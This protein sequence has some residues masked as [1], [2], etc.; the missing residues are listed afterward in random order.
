MSGTPDKRPIENAS[1]TD[2]GASQ[3]SVKKRRWD[4]VPAIATL[5]P[6]IAAIPTSPATSTPTPSTGAAAKPNISDIFSKVASIKASLKEKLPAAAS[7]ISAVPIKPLDQTDSQKSQTPTK[8]IV[9]VPLTATPSPTIAANTGL[10]TSS[11]STPTLGFGAARPT[12]TVNQELIDRVRQAS[13]MIQA[14]VTGLSIRPVLPGVHR[15]APPPMVLRLDDQGREIDEFGNLVHRP[16]MLPVT[17]KVNKDRQAKV[18]LDEIKKTEPETQSKFVDHRLLEKPADRKLKTSFKFVQAGKFVQVAENRRAKAALDEI[19]EKVKKETGSSDLNLSNPK[20]LELVKQ[21]ERKPL[22]PVPSVEWWDE[23]ILKV[24]SYPTLQ[25]TDEASDKIQSALRMEDDSAEVK[26]ESDTVP[27]VPQTN[28][29][30]ST[31][32]RIEKITSFVEHPIPVEPPLD[33]DVAPPIALM[34]TQKERKKLRTRRRLEAA[35]DLQE[36]IQA[37]IIPPPPPKVKLSSLMRVLGNQA[38]QDPTKIEAEVRQQV[39]QRKRVHDMRNQQNKLTSEQKK[40]KFIRK[41]KEDPT[42]EHLVSVYRVD[43]LSNYKFR[44]KIELNARKF[45][46]NGAMVVADEFSMVV[47][48]GG[49]KSNRR[50]SGVMLRRIKWDSNDDDAEDDEQDDDEQHTGGSQTKN[51]CVLVW[52]GVSKKPFFKKFQ[53]HKCQNLEEARQIFK[54][55]NCENFYTMAKNNT[56]LLPD[57]L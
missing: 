45:L 2:G 20:I 30:E 12:T 50:F 6:N 21:T 56:N 3:S 1:N 36:K 16:I 54:E 18:V 23:A 57:D 35:K 41:Y 15:D 4:D 5:V 46:L 39:E 31:Y 24:P 22:D 10:V 52:Q 51:K 48:E 8:P 40:E 29:M 33:P 7:A 55:H 37:G 38:I 34:L 42:Q 9:K 44:S 25:Q 14:Q 27:T 13:A 26:E 28:I 19:R 32:L 47:V 11:S 49:Q 43:D 53:F 17:L